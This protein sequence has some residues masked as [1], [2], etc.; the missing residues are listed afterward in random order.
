MV[1][2]IIVFQRPENQDVL[3]TRTETEILYE[4][5][6][7][8]ASIPAY[9]FRTF[10]E[11]EERQKSQSIIQ[12]S[13]PSIMIKSILKYCT[14]IIKEIPNFTVKTKTL[15]VFKQKIVDEIKQSYYNVALQM[16]R[17]IKCHVESIKNIKNIIIPTDEMMFII[18][19]KIPHNFLKYV[20]RT[21]PNF[22]KSIKTVELLS[23]GKY[24]LI[25]FQSDTYTQSHIPELRPLGCKSVN[26]YFTT[27]DD[28]KKKITSII[29]YIAYVESFYESNFYMVNKYLYQP[30]IST[31]IK[32]YI[33]HYATFYPKSIEHNKCQN[34]T[35][36][37]L[38]L[39]EQLIHGKTCGG[40]AYSNNFL[41]ITFAVFEIYNKINMLGISHPRSK[42]VIQ[43]LDTQNNS[44]KILGNYNQLKFKKKLEHAKKKS[45]SINKFNISNLRNLSPAQYKIIDLMYDKLENYYKSIKKHT[46]DFKIINALFSAISNDNR[47]LIHER[48]KDIAK[49]VKIPQRLDT[50]THILQ[51]SQKIPLI[52]PHVIAKAQKMISPYKNDLIK[53]GKIREYLI[54][55]FSLPPMEDGHFCKIC[56]ELIADV[57]EEEITKYISGKRV[58]FVAEIDPLKQQIWKDVVLIITSYVKFKDS[59]NIKPIVN[60]MTDTLRPELGSIEANLFKIKSNTKDTIKDLMSIYTSIYTFA[61]VIHMINNNYGKITFSLRP[62]TI[63]GG[64][65]KTKSQKTKSQKPKS[66]KT[67][68]QKPKSQNYKSP[69]IESDSDELGE[70]TSS[71]LD[72]DDSK[73]IRKR[74]GE[75]VPSFISVYG[76]K[77]D[78]KNQ[79]RLQ[80]IINN[81]LYLILKTKN[82]AINNV[83]SISRDSIKPI[84]IKAYKWVS[85]L[86]I[87]NTSTVTK[88]SKGDLPTDCQMMYNNHIYHY[89][90]YGHDMYGF[91]KNPNSKKKKYDIETILGRTWSSIEADFKNNISLY[92]DAVIPELWNNKVG[93]VELSKYKYESFKN[94]ME[95]IKIKLYDKN[96]VPLSSEIKDHVNKY[97][98]L[99]DMEQRFFD[100]Q[101]IDQL[102]PFNNIV[103]NENLEITMNDFRPSK[104]QIE[105][106]YDNNGKP[107]IF[108]IYVFQHANNKGVLSGPKKEYNKKD[109]ITWLKTQDIKKTK[110][111]KYM[112]IVDERCSIC[113]TLLSNVKNK[114]VDKALEKISN[115]KTFFLY[116]ENRCPK[117][118][119][120]DFVINTDSKKENSCV[121]CGITKNIV[122]N[123][124]KGYYDKYIKIYDKTQAE[125]LNLEKNDIKELLYTKIEQIAEKTFPSWKINN[126][127]ILELSRTFKIKYNILINLGLS[128][129]LNYNLIETEKINPSSTIAQDQLSVR[130]LCLHGYYLSIVRMY[131]LIKHYDIISHIPYDLKLIMAKN[132]V[133]ELNKKL[134][135]LNADVLIQYDFY[136]IHE[137]PAI[138]TNFLLHSISNA[139]LNISK[140][141]KKAQMN[142]EHDLIIYIINTI[143]K[144]EKMFSL[145][146]IAK[147][148]IPD[149]KES[150]M[151]A[152]DILE[153][154]TDYNADDG[155]E[156]APESVGDLDDLGDDDLDDDFAT[157]ELDMEKNDENMEMHH[158]IF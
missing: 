154:D 127:S 13:L 143:I 152:Y 151:N 17:P 32:N 131:Y 146:D 12:T 14:P 157:N 134:P 26:I 62:N 153:I 82:I 45:I 121:K 91:Y 130:I 53:S 84:L 92:T 86:K 24:G 67:K 22:I 117:G 75:K 140:S 20:D 104:I 85:V 50:A 93:D 44:E 42:L 23:S 72:I 59:V 40:H 63:G 1:S 39:M 102:R 97:A 70:F 149:S 150:D 73:L 88:D 112:F 5:F 120:H 125:K 128:F 79:N 80:N 9:H 54:Q 2:N 115:T 25:E 6:E 19:I 110:E 7:K 27:D 103:L 156:S 15:D 28:T 90:V 142:V 4:K 132:K 105:K 136:K 141:M 52:C 124:D 74:G 43:T 21:S 30:T 41:F 113:N 49:L 57:D 133:R 87:D 47:N 46:S 138:V 94:I 111:F 69:L 51:N 147:F 137:S 71:I 135:D 76:G 11:M 100:R 33:N 116:Y 83:S 48:L 123:L 107:H 77:K 18:G 144:S 64:G 99:K 68:S 66:Q 61:M 119:L 122:D 129:G 29:K 98:F 35:T 96:A 58:S 108:D 60:L 10:M 55:T 148:V 31:Y 106:Y 114:T 65:K 101:K 145:P 126:A 37:T 139:I 56:G 8:Q 34:N 158:D 78:L 36:A 38:K 118:E 109:I 155:Y 95:Y 16:D 3:I 89:L 81:A